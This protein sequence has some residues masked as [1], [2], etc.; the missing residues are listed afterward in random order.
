MSKMKRSK[1]EIDFC[2]KEL[3]PILKALGPQI[4]NLRYRHG[5]LEFGKD[6]TFSY[7]NPLN[8]RVNVGFQA[9][10]LDTHSPLG[11]EEFRGS[12]Y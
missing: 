11:P 3:K 12:D 6:F 4:L 5:N 2:K 9:K 7:V 8:E 1:K 10:T